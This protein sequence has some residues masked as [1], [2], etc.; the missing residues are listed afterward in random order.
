MKFNTL[1][2]VLYDI[3][4]KNKIDLNDYDKFYKYNYHKIDLLMFN[5]FCNYDNKL[6]NLLHSELDSECNNYLNYRIIL[7]D[8]IRIFNQNNIQFILIKGLSLNS[9][10]PFPVTRKFKDIDLIIDF[11]QIS[12]AEKILKKEGYIQGYF[13]KNSNK[14]EAAKKSEIIFSKMYKHE[15]VNMVKLSNGIPIN[16]DLNFLF[17]W[18]GFENNQIPFDE[19]IKNS[20]IDKKLNCRILNKIY[21]CLHLCCHY[22]NETT[23]FVFSNYTFGEPTNEIK[24]FRIIDIILLISEMTT[25][26]RIKLIEY[27]ER[28]RI[29]NQIIYCIKTIKAFSPSVIDERLLKFCTENESLEN[30]VDVFM[31]KSGLLKT[32]P[33]DI[34][35]RTFDLHY[36]NEIVKKMNFSN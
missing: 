33:I 24:L 15:T 32:W 9:I 4:Q 20:H 30:H 18:K 27:S 16:I 22:Y 10:Y 14:I 19:L 3:T 34:Y 5:N 25:S 35:T 23:R 21:M 6:K 2:N 36:K 31:T 13:F 1:K 28:Y 7:N 12:L 17:Q 29:K 11:S 8:L 26:E